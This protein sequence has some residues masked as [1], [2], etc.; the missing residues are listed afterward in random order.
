MTNPGGMAT[1]KA[2]AAV[3]GGLVAAMWFVRA[4]DMIVPGPG[5]AAGHGVVPRTWAGL[6]GIAVAPFIHAD[7]EHLVANT[8]PLLILG[9]L[10]LLRGVL[11]FLFV[12]LTSALVGGVGT[13][14]FGTGDSQHIGASGVVFGL[15]GYLV[16]RTVF[17]RRWSSL[18]IALLVAAGY[19]TAM[20]YSLIPE[21]GISWTAHFFGFV[22]GFMAA[23]LRYPDQRSVHVPA[24]LPANERTGSGTNTNAKRRR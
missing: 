6:E 9:G 5:S 11:E 1:M 10:V 13:W 17:D 18:V 21:D 24:N 12:V 16:F 22:G 7:L 4:L 14:I 20:A 3:L 8:L 2:R 23:R 19:G 15:F